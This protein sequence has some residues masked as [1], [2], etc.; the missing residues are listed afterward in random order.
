MTAI[1]GSVVDWLVVDS[2]VVEVEVVVGSV[3]VVDSVVVE[4]EVV[5]GS[6]VVVDSVVVVVA[7]SSPSSPHPPRTRPRR[8]R[9]RSSG[10]I[11]RCWPLLFIASRMAHEQRR[12]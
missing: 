8:N 1:G 10:L 6:V 12:R 9:P 3:V 7:P 2:V 11:I 4:V 5:V